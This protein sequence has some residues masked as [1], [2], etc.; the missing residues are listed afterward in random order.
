MLEKKLGAEAY[1][2]KVKV[3]GLTEWAAGGFVDEDGHDTEL[4]EVV[5]SCWI[6][7]AQ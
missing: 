4:T 1:C 5:L 2:A 3:P 7:T 6:P